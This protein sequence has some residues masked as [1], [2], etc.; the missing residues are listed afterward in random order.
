MFC[1]KCGTEGIEGNY[2]QKCGEKLV[3]TI[4]EDNSS[5]QQI[6]QPPPQYQQPTCQPQQYQQPM[7]QP[8][9]YQQPVYQQQI[10]PNNA[11]SDFSM[12]SKYYQRAF[13]IIEESN[14]EKSGGFNW[15]AFLGG[16]FWALFKGA[17]LSAIVSGI[18]A[19][20]T[21][22]VGVPLF[23]FIYGFKAN[24]IMY[25]VKVKNKQVIF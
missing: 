17:W 14:E 7:Y 21:F 20:F 24:R 22:G 1:Q 2:C 12:Y 4:K 8:Q 9:Q 15:A 23:W 19:C 5:Y 11:Q 3:S 18:C 25:N 13:K 16:S 6:Q 10:Q